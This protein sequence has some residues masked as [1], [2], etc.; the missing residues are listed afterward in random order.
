MSKYIKP[1]GD[2]ILI[3]EIPIEVENNS[4]L[5]LN[6]TTSSNELLKGEVIEVGTGIYTQ[7]GYRLQSDFKVGDVVLYKTNTGTKFNEFIILNEYD[8]IGILY[9]EESDVKR[10]NYNRFLLNE[11]SKN[12]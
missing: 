4:R 7:T 8:I 6:T 1:T 11:L 9:D 12:A 3:K 5:I 2:K 10:T